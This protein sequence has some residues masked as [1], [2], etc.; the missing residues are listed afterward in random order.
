M[1]L[2]HRAMKPRVLQQHSIMTIAQ[3]CTFGMLLSHTSVAMEGDG[4]QRQD[5]YKYKHWRQPEM[6]VFGD[7]TADSGRRFTAPASFDFEDIGPFPFKKLFNAPDEESKFRAYLPSPGSPTNGKVWPDLLRVPQELNFATSSGTATEA[8]RSRESCLGYTGEG[9]EFPTGTLDEQV[10]R[11]FH[12]V[13]DHTNKTL[14]YTHIISIGGNDFGNVG[15]AVTRYSLGGDGYVDPVPFEKV[16]EIVNGTVQ[17][18]FVPF[19]TELL[20]AWSDGITRL[21][22]AGVTGR[23]LLSNLPFKGLPGTDVDEA[24]ALDQVV[25]AVRDAAEAMFAPYPQVRM[26]DAY[27]LFA[28]LVD[29]PEMFESLGFSTDPTPCLEFL[30]AIDTIAEIMGTQDLRSADCPRKCALCTENV[31]PCQTCLSGNPSAAMCDDA[32]V[33][34]FWDSVHFTAA[35]HE[36]LGEI[37]RQCSKDVPDY[38]RPFVEMSCPDAY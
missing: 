25:L 9:E 6:V 34:I 11:Y 26:L 32:D 1:S 20:T 36:V 21:I 37:V 30:F 7:S 8:F 33:R 17:P 24:A 10:T 27:S 31:S 16:F 19:L 15:D 14:G 35:F 18:T 3:L 4:N 23:I 12:D 13:L 22:E 5:Y 2:Q 29:Q 28:A 38:D